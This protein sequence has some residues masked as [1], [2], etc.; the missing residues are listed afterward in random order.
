MIMTKLNSGGDIID[1]LLRHLISSSPT[2]CAFSA[3]DLS[4]TLF[5][6]ERPLTGPLFIVSETW[7]QMMLL[8]SLS[9]TLT[10]SHGY[11]IEH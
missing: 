7:P 5:S 4:K 3:E 1:T 10:R 9:L 6:V 11:E 8:K 2:Y